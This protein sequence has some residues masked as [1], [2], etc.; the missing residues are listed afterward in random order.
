LCVMDRRERVDGFDLDD[1]GAVHDQIEP[2]ARV[3]FLA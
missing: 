3:K 2:V 1:D